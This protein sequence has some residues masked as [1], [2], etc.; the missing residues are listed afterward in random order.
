MQ[1]LDISEDLIHLLYKFKTTNV[2]KTKIDEGHVWVSLLKQLID[3]LASWKNQDFV[4][5]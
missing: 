4:T 3:L 2:I 1:N 5:Y